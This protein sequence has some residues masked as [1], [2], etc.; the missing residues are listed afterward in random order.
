M[1]MQKSEVGRSIIV[2]K[3]FL[4]PSIATT[5]LIWSFYT[6]LKSYKFGS[7]PSSVLRVALVEHMQYV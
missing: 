6:M 3:N 5:N 1:I 2:Q 7:A 4:V